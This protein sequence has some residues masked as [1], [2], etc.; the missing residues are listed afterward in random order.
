MK[1]Y[2]KEEHGIEIEQIDRHAL[3][4][5]DKLRVAGH[6]AYLVGGSVRDLLLNHKPKDFDISTSAK[7]EE[8]K[9][10]FRNCFLIGKRFR[11]AHIRFGRKVI[12]VATFRAG[13]NE[14][15]TLITEDNI[16]GSAEQD[17]MRRDFTINGLLYDSETETII[18]Y[19][20]G[21]P[22]IKK[23]QLKAI[24]LPYVRFKQD[25]VR[26][27]R[28]LKFQARFGLEVEKKAQI[29]L[30]ECKDEIIKSSQARI[31]E[32]LLRMLESGASKSFFHLMTGH[33]LLQFLL[34]AIASFLEKPEGDEIYNFLDEIDASV[35]EPHAPIY[36]RPVLLSCLLFPLLEHHIKTHFLDRER[37]PHLG[38]IQTE[39]SNVIDEVFKTFFKLPRRIKAC[40]ISLL[41][42]QY[43][44]TPFDKKKRR[45]IR[46]PKIPDF[47]YAI[48]FLE[49]RSRIEPGLQEI[50]KEWHCAIEKVGMPEKKTV[51]KRRRSPKRDHG[52]TK[53]DNSQ[54]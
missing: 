10:L 46:V 43:R 8:I 20:G 36:E 50:V 52:K 24:G 9:P 2:A 40:M 42:T 13:D 4:I 3:Y 38:E 21:Y 41:T 49:I 19:V 25:P 22:E 32:E 17:V 54:Q 23:R 7:P 33:G 16:W 28:M 29:A 37:V 47:A 5:L 15:D 6:E 34:P 44:L 1:T 45:R 26:M 27:L 30:I 11:L 35:K 39:V 18:D 48:H 53:K 14:D 51:R 12:E 31:F